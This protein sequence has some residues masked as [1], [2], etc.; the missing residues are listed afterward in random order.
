MKNYRTQARQTKR[1]IRDRLALV[2]DCLERPRTSRSERT[3]QER[4]RG[5][6]VSS[7]VPPGRTISWKR[8]SIRLTH[9]PTHNVEA[10]TYLEDG[11]TDFDTARQQFSADFPRATRY[12]RH[13]ETAW[14][15]LRAKTNTLRP[16]RKGRTIPLVDKPF[17]ETLSPDEYPSV[18]EEPLS[19]VELEAKAH[20][21]KFLPS[22]V[23][24]LRQQGGEAAL[25]TEIRK[26]W[27]YRDYQI[28]LALAQSPELH[29]LQVQ[30]LFREELFPRPEQPA[31]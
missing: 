3:E 20:W 24:H 30:E 21:E 16:S 13:F 4:R 12:S 25:D 9:Y 14:K 23:K 2:P 6:D 8:R 5:Y 19:P 1:P 17:R 22:R 7:E 28:G 29:R 18:E 26:A 27:T 11:L 31:R 15:L 10:S